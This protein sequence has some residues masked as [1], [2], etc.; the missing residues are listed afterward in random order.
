MKLVRLT[1]LSMRILDENDGGAFVETA[2][3]LPLL[4]I[5]LISA[6]NAALVLQSLQRVADAAAVGARYGTIAGY[7]ADLAGMENA[8]TAAAVGLP[9]FSAT[10]SSYC[11]C[12]PGGP[13]VSCTTT[14][15]GQATPAQYVRVSTSAMASYLF[16]GNSSNGTFPIRS[17]TTLRVGWGQ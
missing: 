2:L 16:Q 8:A 14:C 10:A 12:L 4:I 9:G 7:G 11:T 6:V 1:G 5:I 13:N 3:L 15:A 17:T